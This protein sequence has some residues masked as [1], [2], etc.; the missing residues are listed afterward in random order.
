MN[1]SRKVNFALFNHGD[2]GYIVSGSFIDLG[3]GLPR[4]PEQQGWN[5][6]PGASGWG[7]YQ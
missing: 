1:V 5:S 3:I 6:S 4:L 2:Y 7:K